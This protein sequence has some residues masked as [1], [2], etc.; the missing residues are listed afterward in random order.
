MSSAQ[1]VPTGIRFGSAAGR[2]VVAAT[3]LGSGMAQL[4][5]TVVNVALPAIGR[6]LG[7]QASGLQLVV[8]AYSVTLAALILLSGSL[9]DRVGRKRVFVIGVVWFTVASALCA[10]A[11]TAEM[12]IAARALQGVGGALLTPGSLA[13]I[14]ATFIPADRGKAI[15]A[16]S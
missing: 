10:M 6:D 3:V 12:L 14:Q 2:W 4:D 13:I 5:A 8:S 16:W 7:A 9:G 15:G 1:S 11:P